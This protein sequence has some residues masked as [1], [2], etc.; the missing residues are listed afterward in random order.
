[1]RIQVEAYVEPSG[2]S[3]NWTEGRA[4]SRLSEMRDFRCRC[5]GACCR[6]KD[7]IVRVSDGEIAR[8]A[9][10][11]G[12][13]EDDFIA[14]ETEIAPDRKGLVLKS[15][16]DGAC[17]YLD[18]NNRCRINPVKPEKCRTFPFEWTNPDSNSVCPELKDTCRTGQDVFILASSRFVDHGGRIVL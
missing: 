10:Y 13:A 8:I 15:L 7:G 11:L 2:R 16:P 6:I 12:M 1:M 18:E 5:C 3:A 4:M 9:A 17:A 14:N